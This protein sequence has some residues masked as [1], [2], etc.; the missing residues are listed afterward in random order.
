MSK[1][2]ILSRL[3]ATAENVR[4]LRGASLAAGL[5]V[6]L[7]STGV[8]ATLGHSIFR[9]FTDDSGHI[10]SARSDVTIS[11]SGG[12]VVPVNAPLE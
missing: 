12:A 7:A 2:M 6:T 5:I 11:T 4:N 1:K 10:Q 3:L 8:A 9:P